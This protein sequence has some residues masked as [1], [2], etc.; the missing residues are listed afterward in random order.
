MEHLFDLCGKAVAHQKLR[1]EGAGYLAERIDLHFQN[2][3]G[4]R[5]HQEGKKQNPM[6]LGN[7]IFCGRPGDS[8]NVQRL[9]NGHIKQ[10]LIWLW[11]QKRRTDIEKCQCVLLTTASG[12]T[13]PINSSEQYID[14]SV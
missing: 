13:G 2:G 12:V 4:F 14:N 5:I 11:K 1:Q 7:G 10:L 3:A 6:A 8:G 9:R